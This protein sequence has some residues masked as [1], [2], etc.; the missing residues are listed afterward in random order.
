MYMYM[1]YP[2]P[3]LQ[4]THSL[5]QQQSHGGCTNLLKTMSS[6]TCH[7]GWPLQFS[8]R[9]NPWSKSSHFPIQWPV[10]KSPPGR[11]LWWP[12][13]INDQDWLANRT[14][15]YPHCLTTLSVMG[16]QLT[17]KKISDY[18]NFYLIFC[19]EKDNKKEF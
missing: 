10:H 5:D 8:Q 11:L 19:I 4:L 18:L 6:W 1:H 12:F 13:F 2:S 7:Q 16:R 17:G 9:W 15:M 3:T 14:K